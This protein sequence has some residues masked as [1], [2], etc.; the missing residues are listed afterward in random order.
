MPDRRTYAER[1]ASYERDA[2]A[3][4]KRDKAR[5]AKGSRD[6]LAALVALADRGVAA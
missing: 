4:E 5:A 6:L 3:C 1:L 2:E